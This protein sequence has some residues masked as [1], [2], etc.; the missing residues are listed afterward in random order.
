MSELPTS[1][2]VSSLSQICDIFYYY[3]LISFKLDLSYF[4]NDHNLCKVISTSLK[5][6]A[7]K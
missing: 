2:K 1:N 4:L 3:E 6:S 7:S 5:L